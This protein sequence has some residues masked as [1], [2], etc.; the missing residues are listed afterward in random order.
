MGGRRFI[1]ARRSLTVVYGLDCERN[2]S[3]ATVCS[4]ALSSLVVTSATARRVVGPS[5][6][7]A[8][9]HLFNIGE[10]SRAQ[11]YFICWQALPRDMVR[12]CPTG[13]LLGLRGRVHSYCT[14]ARSNSSTVRLSRIGSIGWGTAASAR[15][16]VA[17]QASSRLPVSTTMGG[18]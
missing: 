16:Q 12:R 4:P 7:A 1:P 2:H 15:D 11:R 17:S 10:S 3:L 6:Q 13:R 8:S 18:P 14:G 5:P 9:N